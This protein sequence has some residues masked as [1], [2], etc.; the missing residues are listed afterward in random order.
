MVAVCC[1][2]GWER[3]GVV[4]CCGLG[5]VEEEWGLLRWVVGG[6][7]GIGVLLGFGGWGWGWKGVASVRGRCG[8]GLD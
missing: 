6:E 4:V 3:V 5:G 7:G 2:V 8:V 1:A